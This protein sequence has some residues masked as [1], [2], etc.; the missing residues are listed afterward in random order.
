VEVPWI[1]MVAPGSGIPSLS[2]T[3]PDIVLCAKAT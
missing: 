3:T 2:E 1:T